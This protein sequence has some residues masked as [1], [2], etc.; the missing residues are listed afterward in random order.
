MVL[1]SILHGVYD[2]GY[3]VHN[4]II[5]SHIGN[6]ENRSVLISAVCLGVALLICLIGLIT[7]IIL[8]IRYKINGTL[9]AKVDKVQSR[10]TSV[11]QSSR[12]STKKNISYVVHTPKTESH[13]TTE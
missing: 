7:V 8:L 11:T 3:N 13:V 1:H 4:V 9:N 12:I 2:M 10:E 5:S 6:S